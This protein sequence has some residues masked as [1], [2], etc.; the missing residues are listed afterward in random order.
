MCE[1]EPN[2]QVRA[3]LYA[4]LCQSGS[5]FSYS[6]YIIIILP[7]LAPH[8]NVLFWGPGDFKVVSYWKGYLVESLK[9]SFRKFYG[10]YGDLILQYKVSLSW[11]LNDILTF[12]YLQ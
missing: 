11:M 5:L 7:G 1:I 2:N 10:R 4:D 6:L 8:M 3:D 9:S 12:D